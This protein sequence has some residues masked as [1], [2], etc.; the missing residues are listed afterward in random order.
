MERKITHTFQ[1]KLFRN[2]C[3]F[4]FA[5]D[6]EYCK[7]QDLHTTYARKEKGGLDRVWKRIDRGI[8]LCMPQ[9]VRFSAT[10]ALPL[11][12]PV[13]AWE[14]A[15]ESHVFVFR[16]RGTMECN[17][18]RPSRFSQFYARETIPTGPTISIRSAYWFWLK[19]KRAFKKYCIKYSI[20]SQVASECLPRKICQLNPPPPPQTSNKK[21]SPKKGQTQVTWRYLCAAML[22]FLI[23]HCVG[24]L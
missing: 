24:I 12:A 2:I 10:I 5:S 20:I 7:V 17:F 13:M 22:I 1:A 8:H 19:W 23:S 11:V 18:L 16:L 21:Q 14:L 15:I 9:E 6:Q 3:R 4:L